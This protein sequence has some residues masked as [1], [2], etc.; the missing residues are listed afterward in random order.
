MRN[1]DPKTAF[2][3]N[4]RR[5]A[6]EQKEICRMTKSV[7]DILEQMWEDNQK[8]HRENDARVYR[9]SLTLEQLYRLDH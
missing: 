2:F 1:Q 7:E 9:E 4:F 8:W 6:E 5:M 3:A